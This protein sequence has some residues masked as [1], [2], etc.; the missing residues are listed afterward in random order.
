MVEE[1]Q[2]IV[3]LA[4]ALMTLRA[5]AENP[6]ASFSQLCEALEQA[7]QLLVCHKDAFGVQNARFQLGCEEFVLW[8][9]TLAMQTLQR[10]TH[11]SSLSSASSTSSSCSNGLS[12]E[13]KGCGDVLSRAEQHTRRASGYLCSIPEANHVS[14]R[15]AFRLICLNNLACYHKEIGKPLVALGFLEKALKIQLKQAAANSGCEPPRPAGSSGD[16]EQ[17]NAIALTHLNLCA[18]L[19]QLH[20]HAAAAEHAKSSLALLKGMGKH[21]DGGCGGPRRTAQLVLIAHFNLAV[22][23]EHLREPEQALRTY[24]LAVRFASA[25]GIARE[26][27]DLVKTIED[28][29]LTEQQHRHHG[30]AS[31]SKEHSAISPRRLV[32]GPRTRSLQTTT[33]SS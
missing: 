12:Q 8:S 18:V 21:E 9:N 20:R 14:R 10:R 29:L 6:R 7:E 2:S 23:L 33:S 32:V 27:S 17:T 25:H 3:A 11:P 16:V 5:H 31:R 22:E 26:D 13:R 1:L 30:K 19:S 4:T 15:L 28:I 24:E